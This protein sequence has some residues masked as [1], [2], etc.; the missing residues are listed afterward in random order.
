[1]NPSR[2]PAAE[3]VRQARNSHET[4]SHER[5]RF[6]VTRNQQ[7]HPDRGSIRTSHD[8]RISGSGE[9]NWTSQK[10]VLK[11]LDVIDFM[12]EKEKI[13]KLEFSPGADIFASQ[14]TIF[15]SPH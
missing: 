4:K 10:N 7:K 14:I 12:R 6:L 11:I 9:L 3:N 13:R 2:A 5:A 8:G 15:V 1:M